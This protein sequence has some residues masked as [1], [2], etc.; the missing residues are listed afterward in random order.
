MYSFCFKT[1]SGFREKYLSLKVPTLTGSRLTQ[2]TGVGTRFGVDVA[3]RAFSRTVHVLPIRTK[4]FAQNVFFGSIVFTS[5][6]ILK[7]GRLSLPLWI[8]NAAHYGRSFFP[9]G[10]RQSDPVSVQ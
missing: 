9:A 2:R 10:S 5:A 3:N 6:F 8:I 7:V 4:R 1:G